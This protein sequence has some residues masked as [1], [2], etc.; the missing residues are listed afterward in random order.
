MAKLRSA[1]SFATAGELHRAAQ[2]LDFA[3]EVRSGKRRMRSSAKGDA[4]K[5]ARERY[6]YYAED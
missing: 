1:V 4:R 6:G 3:R 2:F 5:R